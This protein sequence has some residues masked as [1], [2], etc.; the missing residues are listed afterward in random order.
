MK[1]IYYIFTVIAVLS[2]CTDNFE[3]YNTDMKNPASVDGEYLF[4]NAEK[5]LIDHV[6]STNVNQNIF[7]LWAQYWNET[8]Y[9]DEA[10]YDLV[11]RNIADNNFRYYYR[12]TLM[13]LQEAER[14][15]TEK[16]TFDEAAKQNK[17]NIIV[18]LRAYA[19]QE[20]VDIFGAVPYSEALN[21]E[22][23]YP[24]Y[25]AGDEIYKDLITKVKAAVA[26]LKPTEDSYGSADL[27]YGGDVAQWIKF[28]NALLIKLGIT[29]ID[30]DASLASQTILAGVNGGAFESADDDALFAY[31]G[32]MPNANPIYV[33]VIASGRRDFVPANTITDIMTELGDPRL[34]AYCTPYGADDDGNPVYKGGEY[35][36][37]TP[38]GNYSHIPDY[39]SAPDFH[40]ILMT[41]SEIQFYLAEAAFKGVSLPQS[42]ED[43][44]VEAIKTS[45]D[46]WATGGADDY[47]ATDAV[48][49]NAANAKEQIAVQSWIA[50]Y[51]RG[52][53]GYTTWRRL[54]YPILNIAETI[55]SYSE[56]PVR[57][58]FPVNEQT[59]NK[60]Q[61][62][63][64]VKLIS[65]GDLMT[66][67]IFWDKY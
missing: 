46:F 58:T 23:V 34:P 27:F 11:T 2:A 55:D 39:I 8:T 50:S 67:R 33:D 37:P 43:Y 16:E 53:V 28:G 56:I 38:Y 18:L 45:F 31:L 10:N 7:K 35:G 20:L 49:Y 26:A 19:Y 4:S 48:K 61:Y 17:L 42:A 13:D 21:P 15:I 1:K 9:T 5:A 32:S 60:V 62:A 64:A 65:G 22:N 6:S 51:T 36:Y 14:L 30:S 57:F 63:E 47:I 54:D 25:Q 52:L 41:Y 12:E 44:Y 24:A 29:I 40:G 3:E 59:L 66:S